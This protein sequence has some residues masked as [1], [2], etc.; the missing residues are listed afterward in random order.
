MAP[1]VL[2]YAF[3]LG[4]GPLYR[5]YVLCVSMMLPPFPRDTPSPFNTR[6]HRHIPHCGSSRSYHVFRSRKRDAHVLFPFQ[7]RYT[8]SASLLAFGLLHDVMHD[9]RLLM[10]VLF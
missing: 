4:G 3:S 6:S 2:E 10:A 1:F 7:P 5:L 8:T 9:V